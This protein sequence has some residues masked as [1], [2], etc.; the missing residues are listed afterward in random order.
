MII[1]INQNFTKFKN[2]IAFIIKNAKDFDDPWH[3]L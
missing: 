2:L 1:K 3:S